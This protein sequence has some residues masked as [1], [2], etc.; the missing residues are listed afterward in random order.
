M[1][2]CKLECWSV[3]L[4]FIIL[5]VI[6]RRGP[7]LGGI[8][9]MG[10]LSGHHFGMR[11]E[12]VHDGTHSVILLDSWYGV[13]EHMWGLVYKR[14]TFSIGDRLS[15]GKSVGILLENRWLDFL[16]C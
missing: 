3:D 12:D 9:V 6:Y 7:L 15:R 10:S 4:F 5:G 1:T 2:E 8:N 14:I 16:N 13:L 11:G